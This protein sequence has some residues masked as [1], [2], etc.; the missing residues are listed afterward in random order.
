M[1]I[2]ML[3]LCSPEAVLHPAAC[4]PVL[5]ASAFCGWS[6]QSVADIRTSIT[7]LFGM[8]IFLKHFI[9]FY[10]LRIAEI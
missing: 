4:E 6:V 3:P 8:F 10:E 1:R 2:W 7:F 5:A 9:I